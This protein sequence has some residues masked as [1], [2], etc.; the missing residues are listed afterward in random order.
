MKKRIL[1]I[2][3]AALLC[4]AVSCSATHGASNGAA[5]DLSADATANCYIVPAAGY[6][7]FDATT[8]GCGQEGI[9]PGARFHTGS[10]SISPASAKVLMNENDAISDITFDG[11]RI[12]FRAGSALGNAQIAVYDAAGNVLW[13]WHIWRTDAPA[14]F[15]VTDSDAN[16]WTFMDRN[17]GAT[18]ALASDGEAAYGLYYQWGRK[19]PFP[20]QTVVKGLYKN[21]E[22]NIGYAVE[23][24][25]RPL[26]PIVAGLVTDAYD[27]G[28]THKDSSNHYLWGNPDYAYCHS[29]ADLSK[30]IYDP[31]PA[32]YMVAP[33][34]AYQALADGRGV[35]YGEQGVTLASDGK[36]CFF[37]Y[38]GR[39]Y[40]G[41]VEGRG[42][43]CALWNSGTARYLYYDCGGSRVQ[44]YRDTKQTRLFYG[45][46]RVRCYPVRCV[47][48][49]K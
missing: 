29:L 46:F 32:G 7:S 4:A 2:F 33:G 18:G 31:C 5:V 1:N 8:I 43:Y 6:Y 26:E 13:S 12:Y 41:G 42:E 23:H 15:S 9:I 34:Q 17:L 44:A 20:A 47:R 49:A 28:T 21:P 40:E 14:D 27:W 37:P 24:P 22:K 35:T 10:A 3:S 25:R 48:E 45:D 36:E 39:A 38:A 19:D 16:T 30:T 11:S